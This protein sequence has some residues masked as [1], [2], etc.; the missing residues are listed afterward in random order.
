[1][2]A[3]ELATMLKELKLPAMRDCYERQ[4]EEARKESASFEEY[5]EGLIRREI[6]QRRIHRTSRWLRESTLPLEKSLESFDRKRLPAKANTQLST[7]PDGSF[8]SRAENILAF[9]NPG[10]GKTHLLCGLA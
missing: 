4:A 1:M 9:G 3:A 7:L 5:L 10:S 2:S 8:L 6:E